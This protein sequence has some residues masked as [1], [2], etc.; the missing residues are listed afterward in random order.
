MFVLIAL[1]FA[2][3]FKFESMFELQPAQRTQSPSLQQQKKP[4]GCVG[5]MSQCSLTYGAACCRRR[6]LMTT[7][8]N[9]VV[10]STAAHVRT[11][12]SCWPAERHGA[13]QTA[14]QAAAQ[15]AAQN[16][17]KLRSLLLR[18]LREANALQDKDEFYN[19]HLC[20]CAARNS[21]ETTILVLYIHIAIFS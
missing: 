7:A 12:C 4:P 6:V 21:S 13:V 9:V 2:P 14:A 16:G 1:L 19:E 18:V 5:A 17:T 20:Q 15:T 8:S 10:H 11:L 3:L